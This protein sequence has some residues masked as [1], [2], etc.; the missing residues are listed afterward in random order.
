MSEGHDPHV[1]AETLRR[2]HEHTVERVKQIAMDYTASILEHENEMDLD[3]LRYLLNDLLP[4]KDVH[5]VADAIVADAVASKGL[6]WRL[7]GAVYRREG[8]PVALLSWET[9]DE[10]RRRLGAVANTVSAAVRDARSIAIDEVGPLLDGKGIEIPA[11]ETVDSL[12]EAIISEGLFDGFVD[13][14]AGRVHRNDTPR[15]RYQKRFMQELDAAA[16]SLAKEGEGRAAIPPRIE[17][18]LVSPDK[19]R[20]LDGLLDTAQ[21][22]SRDVQDFITTFCKAGSKV[23]IESLNMN[24]QQHFKERHVDLPW[25]VKKGG[26]ET[27]LEEMV[28]N[29][30]IDGYFDG[31][32]HFVRER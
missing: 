8:A 12:L 16:A 25:D 27:F 14:A 5:L 21:A 23:S 19:P 30:Q 17:A 13:L 6:P 29:R 32:D 1:H 9:Q 4:L 31:E 7:E 11:G 15:E 28:K 3:V 20:S 26:I 18:V 22:R 2:E 10:A 24:L